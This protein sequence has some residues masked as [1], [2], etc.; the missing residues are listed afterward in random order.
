LRDGTDSFL[1]T[2][3]YLGLIYFIHPRAQ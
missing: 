2:D 3:D 1:L